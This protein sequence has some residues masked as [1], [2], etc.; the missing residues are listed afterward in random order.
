MKPCG[1]WAKLEEVD[2][3]AGEV[4]GFISISYLV[5]ASWFAEI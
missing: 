2:A 1:G 3:L 5:S 4:F